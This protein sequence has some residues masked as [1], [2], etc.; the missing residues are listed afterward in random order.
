MFWNGDCLLY[1]FGTISSVNLTTIDAEKFNN[2]YFGSQN[3]PKNLD[4]FN[5]KKKKK[6]KKAIFF[7]TKIYIIM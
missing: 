3:Y 6:K 5:L 2:G 4:Y 7:L 1:T